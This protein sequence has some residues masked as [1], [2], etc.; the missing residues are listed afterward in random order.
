[1]D[2]WKGKLMATLTIPDLDDELRA[3]LRVRAA[4][5]GR[6]MEAGQR[7]HPPQRA[8][9][10]DAMVVED[11][12][13][14]VVSFD[15]TA[16]V[17]YADIAVRCERA[18]RPISAADAQIEAICRSHDAVLATRNTS[19]FTDAGIIVVNPWTDD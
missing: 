4:R 18:G 1:M 7:A 9:L 14:C 16:A 15:V 17:H 11:F 3:Q 2:A 10:L 6:S 12:D 13:H 19:D 8:G 5:H